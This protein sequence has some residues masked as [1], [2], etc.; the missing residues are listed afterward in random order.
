MSLYMGKYS[1]SASNVPYG[2]TA[3]NKT[4]KAGKNP[5]NKAVDSDKGNRVNKDSK[6]VVVIDESTIYEL[7]A[8]CMNKQ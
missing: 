2:G 7:D 8:E 4:E 5:D 3:V 1:R 6:N